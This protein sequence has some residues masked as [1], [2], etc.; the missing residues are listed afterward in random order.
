MITTN[1]EKLGYYTVGTQRVYSKIEACKLATQQNTYVEWHFCDNVWNQQ[2]WTHQPETDIL[3]LYRLR[4]R[5]I[6][7]QYDHVIINYSGGSDSQTMVDAFLQSGSHIDEIVTIW[8]RAHTAKVDQ[9]GFVADPANIEAEYDLTTKPGLDRIRLASPRTKITYVDIS[10]STLQQFDRLDGAEWLNTTAEHL[11]PQYVTR[12]AGTRDRDQLVQLDRG[13][14]TVILFGV[15]KPKVCIKDGRYCTYFVDVVVNSFRGGWNRPEYTNLDYVFF[16]WTPDFPE[17]V[18][19]QSHLIKDWFER[20][21]ALKPILAW[22]NHDYNKRQAYEIIA[23]SIIY[24]EW[25]LGVFQCNKTTSSV[26]S[27]WDN[28]F[29][30]QYKNSPIY[31]AWFEGIEHVQ[32]TIDR[33]FLAYNFDGRFEGFTG[34]INGHFYLQT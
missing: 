13:G 25:D 26:W 19:K 23:R 21:P 8:N 11:H 27:E 32:K 33:R 22:P 20:N 5:Q 30:D 7:E 28:W 14:R 31:A 9:S 29:F 18:I 17:I 10:E 15:D 4:A 1:D 24:P 34:M 3:E 16:Y 12:W 2:D 6:R